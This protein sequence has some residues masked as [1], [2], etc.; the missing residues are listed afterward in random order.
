MSTPMSK[1]RKT[2]TSNST[3]LAWFGAPSTAQ[4]EAESPSTPKKSRVRKSGFDPK[5]MSEFPWLS[6]AADEDGMLCTYCKKYG[7]QPKN[8]SDVWIKNPCMTVTKD[9][10]QRHAKSKMHLDAVCRETNA[11]LA[12]KGQG[13]T[14]SFAQQSSLEKTALIGAFKS[15]YWLAKE[16]IAH[17]THFASLI[18][19]AKSLGCDYLNT[20]KKGDNV[21]YTSQR[22]MQDI[23]QCLSEQIRTPILDDL[24]ESRYFS[25]LIDETTDIAVLKQMTIL[26]RFL[27]S[28]PK[29]KLHTHFLCL[30]DLPDGKADTI[31][32]ALK[33][34]FANNEIPTRKLIGLGSDGASVMVGRK[35][36]VATQL[37]S[38]NPELINVHCI[39]HRLALASAQAA[40]AVP[41][42]K[43]FKAILQQMFKFYQNSA[44]RMAGLKEFESILGDP[45]VKLREIADTRWLSHENAV[46]AIR[47]CLPSLITSL[48][49]EASERMD[50]TAAGLATFVKQPT[51]I[52]SIAMLSNVLPHLSRLSKA[53][54]RTSVDFTMIDTLVSATQMTLM[55]M[56]VAP[57]QYMLE[58]DQQS[59]ALSNFGIN[60]SESAVDAFKVQI[61]EPYIQHVIDNLHD[62]FPD[63]NILDAFTVM[64]PDLVP[65]HDPS[66]QEWLQDQKLQVLADHFKSVASFSTAKEEFTSLREILA[67]DFKGMT[68]RDTLMKIVSLRPTYPVL[69]TYAEIAL[70]LPVS[71]ADCERVFST[72]GRVKTETG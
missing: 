6:H 20:L 62:R 59:D 3:L 51:F 37:K 40:D 18:D 32:A 17:T 24:K 69:A 44:V 35:T 42:L 27:K 28:E 33:T 61:Y 54:Q 49:R 45:A 11:I 21:N 67:K 2:D 47:R 56:K 8:G 29:P 52:C 25:L 16:E 1:K 10:I 71:T 41:Y 66:Q 7:M 64:D 26:V 30:K 4:K 48:E 22:T 60:I 14:S 58:L 63:N 68:F 65:E 38:T 50:A 34:F 15:M 57:G 72:L 55:R 53:F 23:L 13:I 19:L 36:G 46:T 70:I 12:S 31:M 39:A 43:K 9:C 5:W